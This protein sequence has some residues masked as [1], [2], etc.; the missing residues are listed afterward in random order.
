MRTKREFLQHERQRW[1]Q[2]DRRQ[3]QIRLR[4]ITIP[5]KLECFIQVAIE[6]QA[7]ALRDLALRRAD[8][9]GFNVI[10]TTGSSEVTLTRRP[11]GRPYVHRT[12]RD[13]VRVARPGVPIRAIPESRLPSPAEVLEDARSQIEGTER[14]RP[15]SEEQLEQYRE[16]ERIRQGVR[17]I[18]FN[19]IKKEEEE[20][21]HQP[22]LPGLDEDP[23]W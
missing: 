7:L 11:R 16:D 14:A 18:R 12:E 23:P 13:E 19:G 21:P 9:I 6:L 15:P 20:D 3:M 5:R 8:D 22:R 1:T 4:K 2:L 17:K 10:Q